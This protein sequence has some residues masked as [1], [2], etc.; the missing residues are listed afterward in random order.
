LVITHRGG[1]C[2]ESCG[3][4]CGSQ[5]L[6][7]VGVTEENAV[8]LVAEPRKAWSAMLSPLY[9]SVLLWWAAAGL[10]DHTHGEGLE[11]C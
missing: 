4:Y 7:D 5:Q 1:D 10:V 9:V 3:V 8:G 6:L 2:L 11:C